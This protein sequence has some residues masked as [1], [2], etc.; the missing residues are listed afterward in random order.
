MDDIKFTQDRPTKSQLADARRKKQS[1]RDNVAQRFLQPRG[2]GDDLAQR[3]IAE[4]SGQGQR[5]D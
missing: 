1:Y 5:R 2:L 3:R 4:K